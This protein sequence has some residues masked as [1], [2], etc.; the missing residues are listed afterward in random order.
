MSSVQNPEEKK[1]LS[2]DHDHYSKGEYDKGRKTWR[3]KE[4]DL[5]HAYRRK[6]KVK[7]GKTGDGEEAAMS[8][9]RV[10]T[11]KWPVM[12]LRSLVVHKL[13]KRKKRI[14]SKIRRRAH[15]LSLSVTR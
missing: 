7:L 12:Q 4:R 11:K 13:A 2:L 9:R 8:V 10:R 1:R 5:E 14:G 3:R 15:R 6:I